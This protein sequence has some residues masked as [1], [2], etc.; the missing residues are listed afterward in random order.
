MKR[1]PRMEL[2]RLCASQATQHNHNHCMMKLPRKQS[3]FVSH[4]FLPIF[5][6]SHFG[7]Q[8]FLADVRAVFENRMNQSFEFCFKLLKFLIMLFFS[9]KIMPSGRFSVAGT[10]AWRPRGF[11]SRSPF[12]S[13]LM[14]SSSPV[15]V[16]TVIFI[17][18]STLDFK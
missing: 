14:K 13:A 15:E 16:L 12:S 10:T 18:V 6:K 4:N 11:L 3:L 2:L 17:R 5:R 1:S 9:T 7:K 8:Q